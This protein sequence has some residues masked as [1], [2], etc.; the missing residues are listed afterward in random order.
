M[1]KTWAD[2]DDRDGMRPDSVTVKL[3]ADGVNTGIHPAY[4]EQI[5]LLST[6]SYHQ[7]DGRFVVAA[8]RTS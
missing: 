2:A 4:G 3:L 8:R 5:V 6:Y 1:T 7:K